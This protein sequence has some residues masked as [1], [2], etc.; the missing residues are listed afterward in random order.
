MPKQVS[1][2]VACV[3][4]CF[5]VRGAFHAAMLPLWEGFDEYAHFAVFEHWLHART[6]PRLDT[7]VADGIKQSLASGPVSRQLL[8]MNAT[9]SYDDYWR[10]VHAV[11]HTFPDLQNYEAQQPPLYYWTLLPVASLTQS[12][13]MPARV[14]ALR[15]ASVLL[16]S[17]FLPLTFFAARERLGHWG[18]LIT[19]ALAAS[20]PGLMPDVCRIGNDSLALLL[21][22]LLILIV[23]RGNPWLTGVVLGLGLLTKATFLA[24]VPALL[25]V[26]VL[27]RYSVK[28]GLLSLA[29][30]ALISAWWYWAI[31]QITGS[32]S[33]WLEA[34]PQPGQSSF[35][36]EAARVQ[37]LVAAD[38]VFRSFVWFGDWSFLTVKRWMYLLAAAL[39][40]AAAARAIPMWRRY[41]L[42]FTLLAAFGCAMAYNVVLT[43][44]NHG[45]SASTGWY[46]CTLLSAFAIVVSAG[47]LA[48]QRWLPLLIAVT[49]AIISF[50]G[51][52]FLSI[53]Y[54]TGIIV[55][56]P[57]G[58][59]PALA[60]GAIAS[61]L[62]TMMERMPSL[63]NALWI[64][65]IGAQLV[66]LALVAI[67][68]VKVKESR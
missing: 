42:E 12:Q 36:V 41:L 43:H 1:V 26:W 68:C 65:S 20:F 50:Y 45:I 28:R 63:A 48:L 34:I 21:F 29:V 59:L 5:V 52:Q 22:A 31:H 49:F 19:I 44:R 53:P 38:A 9:V 18:S 23:P 17:C 39:L 37:W 11:S 7:P 64:P 27:D 14:R 24:A 60:P 6:L 16:A 35:L 46:L 66:L 51:D 57:G 30:A 32:W 56:A 55:H 40:L 15:I 2:L 8:W 13:A 25:I 58:G 33:G 4:L 67:C 10:G 61:S 54:Y 3:W 62:R 47:A